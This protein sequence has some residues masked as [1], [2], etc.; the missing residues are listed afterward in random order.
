MNIQN[1]Y[2]VGADIIRPQRD[3]REHSALSVHG[4]GYYP[5]AANPNS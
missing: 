3:M 4:E 1:K 2:P 5:P